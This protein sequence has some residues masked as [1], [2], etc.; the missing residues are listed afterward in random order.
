MK[1]SNPQTELEKALQDAGF[2]KAEFAE[3]IGVC[4]FSVI[5]WCSGVS[6]PS[7]KS[8]EKIKAVLG[9]F[10]EEQSE[11]KPRKKWQSKK[12]QQDPFIKALQVAGL[13]KTEFAEKIGVGYSTLLKWISGREKPRDD[14]VKKIK[15]ALGFY[16]WEQKE[17]RTPF[18]RAMKEAGI[19][20]KEL[21]EKIGVSVNAVMLW[22][23][24][25]VAPSYENAEKIREA[26]GFW[27]EETEENLKTERPY[28]AFGK[29]LKNLRENADE[30]KGRGGVKKASA[31][32]G[33]TATELSKYESGRGIPSKK[34]LLSICKLYGA[35]QK[36]VLNA[37]QNAID[38]KNN[39]DLGV[40]LICGKP[41]PKGQKRYC[42]TECRLEAGK[43]YIRKSTGIKRKGAIYTLKTCPDCGAEVMLHG[44]AYRCPTCQYA[45]DRQRARE[46]QARYKAGKTRR[47]G[48]IDI[49]SVCG[50]EYT[51]ESGM[52]K[53]CPDCR[54]EAA[55]EARRKY[56]R[57]R[58]KKIQEDPEKK[59]KRNEARRHLMP[60]HRETCKQCGKDFFTDAYEMY[61]SQECK[62]AARNEYIKKYNQEHAAERSAS[63]KRKWAE[64]KKEEKQ[65]I[66]A[67]RR[68][69][70]EEKKEQDA[71]KE[72]D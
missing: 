40:C 10:P 58:A 39:M 48:S 15:E 19:T 33:M 46:S 41:I 38:Q 29:L 71:K 16:P 1:R 27:P 64:K 3:K 32:L 7:A 60:A 2:T 57:E 53:Y 66:Y 12:Y 30:Y 42:S 55:L 13:T 54:E 34:R 43:R 68:K 61:C 24:G 52:Q 31:A 35:N 25:D 50:K 17:G 72:S 56:A 65:E 69:R 37:R 45:V 70:K 23:R 36:I 4:R 49:C 63:K 5:K 6:A 21:A 22:K 28:E 26:F 20:P 62:D 8:T 47:I 11:K 51:V 59:E 14:N 44:S 9:F 67:Q 18:E